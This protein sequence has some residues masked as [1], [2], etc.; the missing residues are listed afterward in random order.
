MHLLVYIYSSQKRAK[1]SL[2]LFRSGC[3]W[4]AVLIFITF[5]SAYFDIVAS[6]L[7]TAVDTCQL[8]FQIGC[9]WSSSSGF[10]GCGWS[11]CCCRTKS[12]YKNEI[13]K[14]GW[15]R[16]HEIFCPKTFWIAQRARKFEKVLAQKTSE[17]K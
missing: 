16:I 7:S 2:W 3:N 4:K 5:V 15:S 8:C 6:Y 9:S 1:N 14:L 13:L 11:T 12:G 10:G 17:I